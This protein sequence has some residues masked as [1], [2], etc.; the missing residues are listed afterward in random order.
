[1]D[2]DKIHELKDHYVN[3]FYAQLRS[4]QKTDLEFYHDIFTVP[5]IK[6]PLIVSRTGAGAELIDEPV[7]QLSAANLIASRPSK[8]T[9]IAK[10]SAIKLSELINESW[11]RRSMKQNPNPKKECY[12]NIFLFGESWL[13]PVHNQAWVTGKIDKTRLPVFFLT[14]SP[15][16]LFASPNEDE[17]GIPEHMIVWYERMPWMVKAKY[18][19]WSDPLGKLNQQDLTVN[20]LEYWDKDVRYF[21]AD[22]EAVL[23][24]SPNPYKRVPFIHKVSGFG[25]SSHEGKPEELIV[26]RIRRYRDLLKRDA[27]S[28]SD[29][30][31]IIHMF[32]NPPIEIQG[33]DNHPVPP[34]FDKNYVF[35]AGEANVV[36]PGITVEKGVEKLPGRETLEWNYMIQATLGRK[37]PSVL[38]GTPQGETGRLQDIAYTTAM[39][40][41]EGIVGGQADAWAAAIGMALQMCDEIPGLMPDG[42]SKKDINKN[43]VV[44]IE[45]RADDPLETARKSADGD[46]KQTQGIIDWETNLVEYQGFTQERA[47]EV[48]DNAIVDRVIATDPNIQQLIALN[49]ARELGMEQELSALQQANMQ[50]K[51]GGVGSQGGA[52]REGNIQT[53]LGREQVDLSRERKPGR[54]PPQ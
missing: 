45:L 1:M 5:W 3:D 28:T 9:N 18:P 54:L 26:S 31:S 12:K 52:P 42:I 10:E 50:T 40:K 7:E 43:Y 36:P 48:M 53:E 21:E 33:D 6:P 29:I 49:V 39:R 37:T 23:P 13:H 25:K 15:L 35:G 27:A 24:L 38:Q 30:D 2:V 20:W 47:E 16:I 41:Y 44:E 14:P 32:A 34:D 19:A 4:E 46:R 22:T 8:D 51:Q 11:I 17:N